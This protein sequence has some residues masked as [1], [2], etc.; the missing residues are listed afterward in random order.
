[1]ITAGS[2]FLMFSLISFA[3][4]KDSHPSHTILR[5][6]QNDGG[7]ELHVF[8]NVCEWIGA[9][10]FLLFLVSY[11]KEFQEVQIVTKCISKSL[12]SLKSTEEEL[13]ESS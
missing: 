2:L 10:C 8:S 7:Y 12:S 5:W 6:N 13:E 9:S 11:L 3:E 1:M 4:F